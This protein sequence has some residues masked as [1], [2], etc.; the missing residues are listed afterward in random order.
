MVLHEADV[1]LRLRGQVLP[2]P[3]ARGVRFPPRQR[4]IL[5]LDLLQDLLVSWGHRVSMTHGRL[6]HHWGR[7]RVAGTP[8]PGPVCLWAGRRG[9]ESPGLVPPGS[10]DW[11]GH[12]LYP[13]QTRGHVHPARGF[14]ACSA[15][16]CMGDPAEERHGPRL[17]M[18]WGPE[19]STHT[20][21]P[22]PTPGR[23]PTWLGL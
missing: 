10:G 7:R 13:S 5:H 2:L 11:L 9:G 22:T 19:G 1:V 12:W 21:T 16:V 20:A 6:L 15:G 4:L 23:D 17:E 18:L 14:A 8:S 3:G